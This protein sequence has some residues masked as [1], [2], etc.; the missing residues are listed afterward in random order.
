MKNTFEKIRCNELN[1]MGLLVLILVTLGIQQLHAQRNQQ[2]RPNVVIVITDDQGM[3]DIGVMG[4]SI[5]KTP[6]LD[7]LAEDGVFFMSM[8][9]Y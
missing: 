6:N 9:D 8:I 7:A 4:N 5:I 1:R 3:G 2:K